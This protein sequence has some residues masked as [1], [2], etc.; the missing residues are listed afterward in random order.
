MGSFTSANSGLSEC[1]MLGIKLTTQGFAH[2][3]QFQP[4]S[5][6]SRWNQFFSPPYSSP[7]PDDIQNKRKLE[8]SKMTRQRCAS[9]N[10]KHCKYWQ[11]QLKQYQLLILCVVQLAHRTDLSPSVAWQ[12]VS[13]TPRCYSGISCSH[14]VILLPAAATLSAIAG[15]ISAS[16]V[17][18]SSDRLRLF[19]TAQLIITAS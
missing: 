14:W 19:S 8:Q 5:G 4:G 9:N 16:L 10:E 2:C 13:M 3:M 17:A 12:R 6:F 1:C 15:Y 11:T 18:A 7:Y